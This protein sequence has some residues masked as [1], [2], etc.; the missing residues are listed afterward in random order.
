[1]PTLIEY[2]DKRPTQSFTFG[3]SAVA[4]PQTGF[5]DIW[6]GWYE[7]GKGIT[8]VKDSA[9]NYSNPTGYHLS[10]SEGILAAKTFAFT[11]DSG[12]NIWASIGNNNNVDILRFTGGI[13][14][15][16]ISFNGLYPITYYNM[17]HNVA[18]SRTVD[19]FYLKSGQNKI[20]VKSAADNF[21]TEYVF[22]QDFT[23][24]IKTLNSV[25]RSANHMNK[26]E[27]YGLFDNGDGFRLISD[28]FQFPVSGIFTN[29]SGL[30]TGNVNNVN[31]YNC[32]DAVNFSPIPFFGYENFSAY[33]SGAI[34]TGFGSGYNMGGGYVW[35]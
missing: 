6:R 18:T 4:T 14:F 1:M 16:Q 5:I 35:Q 25:I 7:Q 23:K 32:S 19:C 12:V 28:C 24:N 27:I 2:F 31:Q 33:P 13:F 21:A 26:M 3:P 22:H 30:T 15:N 20:Y 17:S 11:F 29:F 8:Y 34:P 9:Y 10:G